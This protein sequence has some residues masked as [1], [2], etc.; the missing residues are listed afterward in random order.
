MR[1]AIFSRL[2][3]AVEGAEVLD[4]F[5]GTGAF[6]LEAL[7][8]GAA[9]VTL[10]DR[11]PKAIRAIEK[12]AARVKALERLRMEIVCADVFDFIA[13]AA[14]S[15]R[16]WDVIFAGPPYAKLP[17]QRSLAQRLLQEQ[18]VAAILRHN[19]WFVVE[20]YKKETV[21]FHA[22]WRLARTL[23]HGDTRVEFLFKAT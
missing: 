9:R 15:G 18:S 23:G 6:G 4:L 3:A 22:P 10:V 8:R 12:N 21:E 1:G 17:S 16:R 20:H 19:G 5:A 2:G 11:F 14:A 7:S 13:R